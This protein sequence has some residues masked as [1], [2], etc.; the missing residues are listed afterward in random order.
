MAGTATFDKISDASGIVAGYDFKVG[1]KVPAT[2]TAIAVYN[3]L[4]YNANLAREKGYREAGISLADL[5]KGKRGK[6]LDVEAINAALAT[7]TVAKEIAE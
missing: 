1:D 7:D 4:T 2:R 3:G 6:S 5:P